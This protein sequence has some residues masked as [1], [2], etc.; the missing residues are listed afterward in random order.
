M[1]LPETRSDYMTRSERHRKKTKNIRFLKY[2]FIPVLIIFL[3]GVGYLYGT[4]SGF[5]L[6]KMMVGSVL[7]TQHARYVKYM[8]FLLPKS[9]IE[10]LKNAFNHPPSV[11]TTI[12]PS[13][14]IA[15][16]PLTSK[17]KNVIKVDTVET[18][19]YTAKIMTVSNPRTIH[20]VT[21]Q[22]SSKGQ[23]LSELI[24]EYNGVAG[25]NAGG[26]VDKGGTG[27]G[28]QV[29]GIEISDGNVLATPS[30]GRDSEELVGAF[31]S[32][33][34]FITGRYSVNELV[35]QGATQA[36]SF[37]PQLIVNGQNVVTDTLT[38]AWGWAPRTA[39][40]QEANGTV[41]M[42]I[43]DGRFYWNKTH[44]GASMSDIEQLFEK[45]NVTNAI[46]MDGG[47]STTMI[48]DGQLQLQP[49]TSTRIGMRYLPN[50]WVVIPNS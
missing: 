6:R 47:G 48:K 36:V 34:Q 31:L 22:L 27:S 41:V 15:T 13:S 19:N 3:A 24:S 14:S 28:G 43:T 33:G 23:G 17:K 9:Q 16:P 25:I 35:K 44:R 10:V 8:T 42:I 30:G 29:I 37:G 11:Q 12:P 39:I 2:I 5:E 32:N 18:P 7:S 4:N 46:A 20:L 49:A 50:A 40:G 26:F 1:N 38:N 21:S 45:Y